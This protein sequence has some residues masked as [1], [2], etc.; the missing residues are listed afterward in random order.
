MSRAGGVNFEAISDTRIEDKRRIR[1]QSGKIIENRPA[2]SSTFDAMIRMAAGT[3]ARTVMEKIADPNRPTWEQ[4]KKDNEDKLEMGVAE[5]KKM[6]EYRLQL[7]REREKRLKE[8]S[9]TKGHSSSSD[10]DNDDDDNSESDSD[11]DSKRKKD[12]KHKHK[13]K[14]EKHKKEKHKKKK[15]KKRKRDDDDN[16]NDDNSKDR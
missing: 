2:A 8:Q 4:Y 16:S 7:D 5:S 12:K 11:D 15:D 10:D 14:K 1:E 9:K 3:Q 6:L 13:H